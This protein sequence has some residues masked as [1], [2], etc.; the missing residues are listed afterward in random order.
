MGRQ[1]GKGCG[2]GWGGRRRARPAPAAGAAPLLCV[3]GG[4]P[5]AAAEA[6]Q[7]SAGMPGRSSPCGTGQRALRPPGS[8]V[9]VVARP[10]RAE[11]GAAPARAGVAARN[12]P[13]LRG[14]AEASAVSAPTLPVFFLSYLRRSC[15]G[16][17][18]LCKHL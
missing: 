4:G 18:A 8:A 15:R 3:R 10:C 2:S 1:A 16:C 13:Q 5:G 7:C 14:T 9:P 6:E 12:S 17:L 11:Q